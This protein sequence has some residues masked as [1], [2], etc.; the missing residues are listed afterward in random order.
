[1]KKKP[2]LN[3]EE[4]QQS[5]IDEVVEL[6][7]SNNSIRKIAASLSISPI[8]VRK[9]LI[10]AG[11]Y[12]SSSQ[13]DIE[14]LYRGGYSIEEIADILHMSKANVYSYLP[15]E[16][17]IYNMPEKS[18]NAD[19]QA[20]YRERKKQNIK[21]EKPEVVKPEIR[22]RTGVMYIVVNQ[23]LRK[24]LPKEFCTAER[25]PLDRNYEREPEGNIWTAY[26]VLAGRGK[27]R[28]IA[29]A[30][31]NARCGF[32]LIMDMPGGLQEME[33]SGARELLKEKMEAAIQ[34]ELLTFGIPEKNVEEYISNNSYQFLFIKAKPSW[35][36][37][38]VM[39]FAEKL[40]EEIKDG[41]PFEEIYSREFNRTNRKFGNCRDYR[42]VDLATY[43]MMGLTE[44]QIMEILKKRWES[45]MRE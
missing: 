36:S 6:F 3:L 21:V 35:P 42:D 19:R 26:V 16:K 22:R 45:M 41:M 20:R 43:H 40:Q 31:E 10:T 39:E 29:I 37:Q 1:M 33:V 13:K 11:V 18:V 4:I 25:D 2:N 32:R 27:D 5:M 24:Y 30:L 17:V 7:Q 12:T 23:R 38:N 9:I 28:K 44:E 15:Y 34:E 8:K 14:E